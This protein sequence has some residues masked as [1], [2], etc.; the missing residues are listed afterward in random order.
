M[1]F[2]DVELEDLSTN[3][4]YKTK[5][6]KKNENEDNSLTVS[7]YIAYFIIAVCIFA[8]FIKSIIE[9]V[10]YINKK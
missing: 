9:L 5:L 6:L 2:E 8:F 1:N 10:Y 3:S 4:N 7:C